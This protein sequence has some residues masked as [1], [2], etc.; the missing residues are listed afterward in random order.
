MSHFALDDAARF[1][2][3]RRIQHECHRLRITQKV[4]A[5]RAGYDEKTIRNIFRGIRVRPAILEDVCK[6][7]SLTVDSSSTTSAKAKYGGYTRIQVEEYEGRFLAYRRS[8]SIPA[9]LVRSLYEFSWND[10]RGCLTFHETQKYATE[11]Q[12]PLDL[13]GEV[14]ISANIGLLHLVTVFNGAVRLITLTRMRPDTL[15]MRG[16]VQTQAQDE[17]FFRPAISPIVMQKCHP[18]IGVDQIASMVGPVLPTDPE[19]QR[20][21]TA[22][23]EI[24]NKVVTFAV[25]GC[26]SK[27]AAIPAVA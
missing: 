18:A 2:L 13:S 22:L 23:N 7:L 20:L 8:F 15:A 1:E 24:E 3:G 19:Y 25:T 11:V 6:C 10:E 26:N 21:N 17:F 27:L 14:F 12:A 9:N 16:S 5:D 4:L